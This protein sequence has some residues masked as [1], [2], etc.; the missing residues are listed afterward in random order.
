MAQNDENWTASEAVDKNLLDNDIHYL[1]GDIACDNI[2][3]AI[4][5]IVS[6][7]LSPKKKTL[8]LYVIVQVVTY[9]SALH[10]LTQ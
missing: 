9:T 3:D 6:R 8:K 1:S 5:F 10:L 4:K 2:A 7:D